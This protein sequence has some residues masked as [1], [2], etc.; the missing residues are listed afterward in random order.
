MRRVL[1]ALAV[2]CLCAGVWGADWFIDGGDPARTG[3]QKDEKI[4][5]TSNV[6]NLKLLWKTHVDSTPREMHNIFPPVVADHVDTTNGAK[7]IGVIAG[8]SNDLYGIDLSEGEQ[9]WHVKLDSTFTP[10]P[11]GRG[12]GTLCPGGQTDVP[13][14][15]PG[16]KPGSYTVYTVGWDGRLFQLNAADG[17]EVAPPQ[18]FMPA[19][20]KPQSL[21]LFEGTIYTSSAQGCGGVTNAFYSFNLATNK[22]SAFLPAG[23]G[24]WGRRGVSIAPDGTAYM[25]TGDGSFY[26][27]KKQLGNAIVAVKLDANKELQL[28]GF[29]GPPDANWMHGRDLDINVTPVP[30]D[31]KGKHFLIGTSKQCRVWLLDRDHLGGADHSTAL[32]RSGLICNDDQTWDSQGMWGALST[33]QDPAGNAWVLVPFWGPV[34]SSFHAP[35]EYG[36]PENGGVAAFKVEEKNGNWQLVP[37]WL[38]RDMARGEEAVIANGVVFAYGSGEN[39]NQRRPDVPYDQTRTPQQSGGGSP[40]RIAG[41]T[42]A[43]LYA[44]DGQTG[45][46]LWSSGDQITS[47]NHMAGISVV[48]GRIYVPTFTGDVY[49]FGIARQQ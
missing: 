35:I 25:G 11:G 32:F 19:N 46:E 40:E 48:N 4:L 21:N 33:W 3:W 43:T 42:H 28:A 12:G 49:C 10:P 44:L 1:V 14:I 8:V 18:A 41:S 27:E 38:S 31:Y 20:G 37:A 30:F 15:G 2:F 6:K 23:G 22:A 9:L 39:T 24:L 34:S 26:P 36:R 29:F 7:Q 17:K 13:V 16:G 47:F 45:K 5:N